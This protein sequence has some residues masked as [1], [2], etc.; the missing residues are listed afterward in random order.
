MGMIKCT[1]DSL[2]GK[3]QRPELDISNWRFLKEGKYDNKEGSFLGL[4]NCRVFFI[5]DITIDEIHDI[6]Y[7]NLTI[8]KAAIHIRNSLSCNICNGMGIIDWIQNV[9]KVPPRRPQYRQY[10]NYIRDKKGPIR[11]LYS[12]VGTGAYQGEI[13]TSTPVKPEAFYFCSSCHASGLRWLNSTVINKEFF[14]EKC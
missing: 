8:R 5:V 12:T 9:N 6:N 14:L 1:E 2:I 3:S 11:N 4:H 7:N 13:F 10:C